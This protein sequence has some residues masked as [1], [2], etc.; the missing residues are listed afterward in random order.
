[1]PQ[2]RAERQI[3]TI[4][5][6]LEDDE[7][8]S[9]VVAEAGKTLRRLPRLRTP[10]KAPPESVNKALTETASWRHVEIAPKARQY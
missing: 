6:Q 10:P 3:A 7:S 2:R 9:A 5:T 8:N 1:M 4:K